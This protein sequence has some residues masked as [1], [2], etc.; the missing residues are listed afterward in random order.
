MISRTRLAEALH[1]T[2]RLD[3][4]EALF[5]EAEESQREFQPPYPL[6]YSLQG[7]LYCDLLLDQGEYDKVQDRAGQTLEW[8]EQ[9]GL[10][11]LTVGLDNL[12]LGRAHLLEA[13]HDGTG[14][15]SQAA[16]HLDR[17][18]D[19]L[20]R[21]G[22]QHHIPRALLALAV[23]HRVRS[24][25]HSAERNLDEA[26][27]IVRRGGMGRHEADAHLEYAHLHLAMGATEKARE[28]LATAKA[29][30]DEMGYHR[31]DP[32]VEDLESQLANA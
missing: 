29:M 31:R 10:S 20:R 1:Q 28:S 8:A 24:D 4:A 2:G 23:L 18:V 16:E 26:M 25:F 19:G 6:L 30:V 22:T 32:E 17:A 5:S 27:S 13:Q 14:N 3:E 15:F 12:A 7:F 21:A 9:H 11:L